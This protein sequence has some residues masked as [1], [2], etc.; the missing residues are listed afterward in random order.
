MATN[1]LSV[2]F[3]SK[4]SLPP[5]GNSVVGRQRL[6]DLLHGN[7]HLRAQ[8]VEA[9]AGY[10]KTT[11][12]ADFAADVESPVCWYSLDGYDQE[13][14]V[15]LEGILASLRMQFPDFGRATKSRLL[16]ANDVTEDVPQLVATLTAEMQMDIPEYVVLVLDDYHSVAESAGARSF[17]NLLVEHAPENCH[18]I[19]SSRAE[20]NLPVLSRMGVARLAATIAPSQLSFTADETRELLSS[21]FRLNLPEEQ[22]ARL[23]SD[24][25][26]WILGVLLSIY[27]L[28]EAGGKAT[29]ATVTPRDVSRYLASEV[30]E[31]QRPETRDFLLKSSIVDI[32]APDILDG[33]VQPANSRKVLARLESQNLFVSCIDRGKGLYRYQ[34]I[35]RDFLRARFLEE[36]PDGFASLHHRVAVLLEEQCQWSE[37]IGHFISARRYDDA[38][39]LVKGVGEDSVN[40]GRWT[41]VAAWIE[42]LPPGIIQ[43]DPDTRL[44]H[45][46]SL[47]HL[48]QVDT[49]AH[50]LSAIIR[51]ATDQG[52]W[53]RIATASIWRSTAFWLTGH[54]REAL[55]DIATAVKVLQEHDGPAAL[56]G[57]AYGRLGT[58]YA[59]QGRL[60]TAAR[61]LRR[62]LRY[63]TT[64]L[65]VLK[66]ANVHTSLGVL[67]KRTGDLPMASTH[68]EHA[69]EGYQKANNPGALAATLN[70]IATVYQRQ[71]QHDLALETLRD[72]L[73]KAKETG[74]RRME[75]CILVNIGEVFR[76]LGNYGAALTTYQ[77]GLELARHVMEPYYVAWATAGLGETHRLLGDCDKA[78]VLTRQAIAL[79]EEQGQDSEAAL[80]TL[81]IGKIA[82]ELGDFD[83]A[84]KILQ[85]CRERLEAA[86]DSDGSARACLHLA[87]AAFLTRDYAE[88]RRWL[89]ETS[90]LADKLGY[91]DFLAVEGKKSTLLI[92]YGAAEHVGGYRFDRVLEKIRKRR[93]AQPA[94]ESPTLREVESTPAERDIEAYALGETRVLVNARPVD[95]AEWRSSRAKELFFYLLG[96]TDSGQ[97]KEQITVSLWPDLSPA[98]ATS[99]FH[100]NLYRARR[101]ISPGAFVVEQG[102]YRLNRDLQLW[103]DVSAFEHYLDLAETSRGN[104]ETRSDCLQQAVELYRGDFMAG[105][106]SE[107][108]EA[109][110][111]DLEGMYLKALSLLAQRNGEMARYG[112]AIGLLERFVAVDPYHDDVYCQMMEWH[113][114]QGDRLSALRTYRRYLD[115]A[116][117]D[118]TS[119]PSARM[120]E[121]YTLILAGKE[122]F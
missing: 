78:D 37:A 121:L 57:D 31:R 17:L 38:L 87:Q 24:T 2:G 85:G 74:Y 103:Y 16:S 12:L 30:Y 19:I 27:R 9:P 20:V 98:K 96:H 109:R 43:A 84:A 28:R 97:T 23:V 95:E 111:R 10:G 36:D 86:G 94:F 110:R 93:A 44:L 13:P 114:A 66:M 35:F 115:K 76:D 58:I 71:G 77:E 14:A 52:E 55:T 51:D 11:L 50:T 33:L 117:V 82:W 29:I 61:H 69:R 79:S 90:A 70:N 108:A 22:L 42:A 40:T 47:I 41:T 56:L 64:V 122:T 113:L 59:E 62:A 118:L 104:A 34:S 1:R 91:D 15:L 116:S 6:I 45:A 7:V 67:H 80:F 18:V 60:K 88:A 46:R 120:E 68:F 75:A 100:I 25:E 3:A 5:R 99:N 54:S 65:D 81:Q 89:E 105:F 72:G 21:Q 83:T 73:T 102:Q 106:Y 92:Q 32:M 39:R 101:A 119:P 48:G 26:G 53:L 112:T 49:A 8:V 107:W 4:V 63:Y